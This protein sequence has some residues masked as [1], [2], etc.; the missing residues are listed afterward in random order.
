MKQQYL[1]AYGMFRESAR[2]IIGDFV[3]CGIANIQGKLYKVNQFYPGY[4][5]SND[6][7][8]K[9][10]GNVFLINEDKLKELDDFEGPEYTR[11]KIIASNDIECW[12]YEYNQDVNENTL[13]KTGDW[14]IRI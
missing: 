11:K 6:T 5:Y 7:N 12:V 8:D 13:I 2:N 9:I 1:F 4:K 3:N 10:W 14:L